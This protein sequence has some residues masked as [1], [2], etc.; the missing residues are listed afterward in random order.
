V[1]RISSFLVIALFFF[2]FFI[3]INSEAIIIDDNYYGSD[4]H[5]Y[6]DVIG[7]VSDFGIDSLDVSI[8]GNQMN[9]SIKTGYTG[10]D[11]LGAG[12]EYGDFFVSTDGWNPHGSTPY[13]S[14]D[15]ATGE[16]WEYAFDVQTGNLYDISGAQLNIL[17]SQDTMPT[18]GYVFRDGQET[19]ID[20]TGLN[21]W[22][23]TGTVGSYDGTYYNFMIDI[24]GLNWNL[25]D[26]GF[27]W[28]A[29]TCANDVIEGSAAPVP[30]PA[31]M[32]LLG[33]GLLGLA[34]FGRRSLRKIR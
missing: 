20:T 27:H 24:S 13:L 29:A 10:S 16:F 6:G 14:D 26:L 12:I 7:N 9:V 32:L 11:S 8:S 3:P 19:A 31:T 23:T 25:S 2:A 18:S 22:T 17:L 5:G 28:A 30:E 34:G 4:D 1:N 33:T 15:H 21:A